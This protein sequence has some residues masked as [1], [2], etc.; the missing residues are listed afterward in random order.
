MS[1]A[2]GVTEH[3]A[4]TALAVEARRRGISYGNLVASTTKGQQEKIIRAYCEE[5][6]KKGRKK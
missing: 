1:I 6:R 2:G 4:L 3:E 5:K